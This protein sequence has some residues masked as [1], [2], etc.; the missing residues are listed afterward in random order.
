MTLPPEQTEP[1]PTLREQPAPVRRV[2]TLAVLSL[3]FSLLSYCALPVVGAIAGIVCGYLARRE[4]EQTGEDGAGAATAGIVLGWVHIGLA[5]L[6]AVLAVAGT[7]AAIWLVWTTGS[8]APVPSHFPTEP[9]PL[10][11]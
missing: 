5:V 8:N 7:T 4:I 6:L 3:I 1:E 10:P 9:G 2:N 11:S